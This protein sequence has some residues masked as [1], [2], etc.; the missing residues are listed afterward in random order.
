MAKQQW[1]D[2]KQV[3]SGQPCDG[4]QYA[5]GAM[6]TNGKGKEKNDAKDHRSH[7]IK[8]PQYYTAPNAMTEEK[9]KGRSNGSEE[10]EIDDQGRI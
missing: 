8:H 10:R 7:E 4:I 1:F 2:K 3:S 5:N 9:K 6:Q